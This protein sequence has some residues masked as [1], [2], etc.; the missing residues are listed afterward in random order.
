MLRSLK[1][2]ERYT[3]SATDGDLGTVVNFLL[4]DHR[5]VVRYLVVESGGFLDGRR[6]LISP[7]FFRQADWLTRRFHLAL[8]MDKVKHSPSVDVDKPVSR[9]HE[10]AYYGYYGYPHYWGGS[11]LWGMGAYP[12]MLMAGRFNEASAHHPE[13]VSGD[14][15]LRSARDVQGYDV[16]GSDEAIGHVEDFVVDDATWA[17]RYLVIDTGRWWFGKKVL[18]APHWASSVSWEDRKVFVDMSRD[19]IKSSPEWL[20]NAAINREYEARLYDY[21]G[22]PVYWG[23]GDSPEEAPVAENAGSKKG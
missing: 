18:I 21:H 6:V 4:D 15:H 5:W 9:Q 19:R 16:Q 23:S 11:G 10:A 3:V 7:I 1:D 2:L 20:P 8:T 12:G 14:A 22:R 17:V 13:H